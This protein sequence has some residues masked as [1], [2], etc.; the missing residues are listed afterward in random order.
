[1]LEFEGETGLLLR[2]HSKFGILFPTKQRNGHSY[3]VEE[4]GKGAF[5]ELWHET[6]CYSHV[7]MCIS[8]TFL[9]CING[10]KYPFA[11]WEGTWDFSGDTAL[12]KELNLR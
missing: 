4:G 7:R 5:L 9:S 11:F 1:M 3:Q 12:E 2:G 10:I 6:Q 8:G